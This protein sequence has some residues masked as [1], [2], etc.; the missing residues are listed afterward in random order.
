MTYNIV[1]PPSIQDKIREQALYIAKDKPSAA[2]SWYDNI[3]DCIYSL[4]DFPNRCPL[5]PEN[6]HFLF[7]L[8]HLIIGNYRILFRVDG[9]TVAVLDFKEGH[10]QK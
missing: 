8:R 1:I 6:V 10:Q 7:E 5:A 2:L 4:A 3:Y 9:D